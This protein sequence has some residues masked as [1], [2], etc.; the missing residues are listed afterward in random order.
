MVWRSPE[1]QGAQGLKSRFLLGHDGPTK[2]RALIQKMRAMP[3][4]ILVRSAVLDRSTHT[5]M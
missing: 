4:G 2:R 1:W 3:L 5:E